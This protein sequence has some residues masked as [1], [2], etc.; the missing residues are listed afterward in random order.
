MQ[1]P[2]TL[3]LSPQGERGSGSLAPGGKRGTYSLAPE[4]GEG[5]VRGTIAGLSEIS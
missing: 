5:R 3:S 2:L 4:G 1:T